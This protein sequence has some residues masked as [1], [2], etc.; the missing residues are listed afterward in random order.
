MPEDGSCG[1]SD[2][3]LVRRIRR[4]DDS[5]F[6][7]LVDRHGRRLLGLAM[8]L[9]GNAAD[10]EDVV[11][12]TLAGAFQ[13]I[14]G[15]RGRSSVGTWLCR[16]LVK[17]IAR[18]RRYQSIRRTLSI[19]RVADHVSAVPSGARAETEQADIR[20]DVMAVL[21]RLSKEHRTVV[22][23]RELQGM[24]YSQIA[25]VLRVPR[26]TVE[27]RLFRARQRL[28]ELLGDYLP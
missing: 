17:R 16:I 21:A 14:R 24:S 12:E 9:L 7:Q 18:L 19:E 2:G 15:F 13:G 26:G 11:Q 4:G 27:S 23:L 25:D 10:A 20:M 6:H 1:E 22:V 28:K 3:A 5:A 8:S